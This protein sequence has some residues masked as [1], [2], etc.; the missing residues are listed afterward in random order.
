MN[1]VALLEEYEELCA[2]NMRAPGHP[3]RQKRITAMHEQWVLSIQTH[4]GSKYRMIIKILC[5]SNTWQD[6]DVS[7]RS[8]F[9]SSPLL[10]PFFS[11]WESRVADSWLW[12]RRLTSLSSRRPID[13]Q[14]IHIFFRELSLVHNMA[15]TWTWPNPDPPLKHIQGTQVSDPRTYE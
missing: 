12:E 1:T 3:A 4:L 6:Q 9:A 7:Y 13:P 10:S 2:A 11:L 8:W 14:L 15:L 5:G